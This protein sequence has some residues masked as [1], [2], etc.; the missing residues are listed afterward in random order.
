MQAFPQLENFCHLGTCSLRVWCRHAPIAIRWCAQRCPVPLPGRLGIR[1]VCCSR[2]HFDSPST[3]RTPRAQTLMQQNAVDVRN[4]TCLWPSLP[5]DAS[6]FPFEIK[7]PCVATRS[8]CLL[9][10]PRCDALAATRGPA[11]QQRMQREVRAISQTITNAAQ[12]QCLDDKPWMFASR[13][14]IAWSSHDIFVQ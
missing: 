8:A 12:P 13:R 7:V 6:M 9:P 14:N 11:K 2:D 5:T 4:C 3:R 10:P 1:C